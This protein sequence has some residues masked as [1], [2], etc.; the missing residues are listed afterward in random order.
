MIVAAVVAWG[1]RG[2]H[3]EAPMDEGVFLVVNA[4]VTSRTIEL[5]FP[6]GE[7]RSAG[8]EAGQAV[9]LQLA[10]SGEGAV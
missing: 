7:R 8:V 10:D 5:R 4:G 9:E 1:A 3:D 6:S 2:L